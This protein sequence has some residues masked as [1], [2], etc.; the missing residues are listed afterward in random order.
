MDYDNIGDNLGKD[1][2]IITPVP[3]GSKKWIWL[4]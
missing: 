4:K 3:Q 1:D 2:I